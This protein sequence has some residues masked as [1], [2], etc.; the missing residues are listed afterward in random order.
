MLAA[1]G[2]NN[3]WWRSGT[4][5]WK[6]SG[7][8]TFKWGGGNRS[9]YNTTTG[10]FK[11]ATFC[12][13]TLVQ[14]FYN[15][16]R[17]IGRNTGTLS[18]Y[19]AGTSRSATCISGLLLRWHDRLKRTQNLTGG[20]IVGIVATFR[21]QV[22]ADRWTVWSR[23]ASLLQYRFTAERLATFMLLVLLAAAITALGP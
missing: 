15:G 12:S 7:S 17:A 16:V 22:A 5:W 19:N 21:R 8:G 6:Q 14:T 11:N 20:T 2:S 13:P 23:G 10:H 1:G 9:A 3:W 18:A 4:G